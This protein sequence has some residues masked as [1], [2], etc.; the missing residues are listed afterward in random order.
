MAGGLGR[1]T[2]A[3]DKMGNRLQ[4]GAHGYH[5]RG[6]GPVELYVYGQPLDECGR[7]EREL[8]RGLPAAWHDGLYL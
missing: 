5:F 6:R 2:I 4:P 7:C 3:Y 8:L 1:E